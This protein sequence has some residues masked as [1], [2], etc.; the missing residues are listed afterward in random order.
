MP[1]PYIIDNFAH[2]MLKE[3]SVSTQVCSLV[4]ELSADVW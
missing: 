2:F 1:H 4:Q 3:V